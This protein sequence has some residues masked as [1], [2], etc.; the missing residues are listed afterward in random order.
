MQENG[1]IRFD[2]GTLIRLEPPELDNLTYPNPDR[3]KNAPARIAVKSYNISYI[4]ILQHYKKFCQLLNNPIGRFGWD[5]VT[6]E[7]FEE[8]RFGDY[9]E[10]VSLQRA[11]Q[12]APTTSPGPKTKSPAELF[13]NSIKRDPTAY[14]TLQKDNMYDNWY[15]EFHA[16]GSSHGLDN[17][18]YVCTTRAKFDMERIHG[19]FHLE[20]GQQGSPI[21]GQH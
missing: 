9:M 14:P 10:N 3:R 11:A 6:R 5:Q 4:K 17:L 19:G 7:D 20:L 13:A 2:V 12:L 21:Q 1:G 18:Y 16:V 8:F 15:R